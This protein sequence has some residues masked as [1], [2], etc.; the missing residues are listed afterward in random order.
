MEDRYLVK[1]KLSS[2]SFSNVY[3]I[4]DLQNKSETKKNLAMKISDDTEEMA[5]EIRRLRQIYFYYKNEKK[6]DI[7]NKRTAFLEHP[8]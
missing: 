7:E 5:L 4:E 8:S 6:N 1:E 3:E 2:G